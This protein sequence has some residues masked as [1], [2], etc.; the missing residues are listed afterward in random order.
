VGALVVVGA[1][2]AVVG[3][4]LAVV[5]VALEA[6]VEVAVEVAVDSPLE[7]VAVLADAVDVAVSIVREIVLA[8]RSTESTCVWGFVDHSIRN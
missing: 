6:G 8:S 3:A 4:A 2:L 5:G 7:V 1:A